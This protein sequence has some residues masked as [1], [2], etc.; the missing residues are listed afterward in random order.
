MG[1]CRLYYVAVATIWGG[2][3]F[4]QSFRIVAT[5]QGAQLFEGGVY[6]K[7][8]SMIHIQSTV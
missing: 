5:I 7:K 8:Y 4:I 3:Y 2:V 6:S 1:A